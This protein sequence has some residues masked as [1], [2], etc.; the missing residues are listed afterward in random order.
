MRTTALHS[1]TRHPDHRTPG[2]GRRTRLRRIAAAIAVGTMAALVVPATAVQAEDTTVQIVPATS[3]SLPFDGT[4]ALGFGQSFLP[5]NDMAVRSASL[6]LQGLTGATVQL[7]ICTLPGSYPVSP[8]NCT[9]ADSTTVSGGVVN[10]TFAVPRLLQQNVSSAVL[11][12]AR[13]PDGNAYAYFSY[14]SLQLSETANYMN[15]SMLFGYENSSGSMNVLWGNDG[16]YGIYADLPLSL[17]Y[18]TPA[19]PAVT[20]TT[21]PSASYGQA[22]STTVLATGT[23]APG[24]AVSG[25]LPAGMSFNTATGVL[26]GTPTDVGTFTFTV[27]ASNGYGSPASQSL[28]LTVGASAPGAPASVTVTPGDH[29]VTATWPAPTSTGG[30]AVT[31][32]VEYQADGDPGWTTAGSTSSRTATIGS[33]TPGTQYAVRVRATNGAGA[34]PWTTSTPMVLPDTPSISGVTVV[35]T[36]GGATIRWTAA[37]GGTAIDSAT[38]RY[39]AVGAPTWT[40]DTFALTGTTGTRTITGL[41]NRAEHEFS[42]TTHN[43]IGDSAAA[44]GLFTPFRLAGTITSANT[45]LDTTPRVAGAPVDAQ[46]SGIPTGRSVELVY[47]AGTSDEVVL[48]DAVADLVGQVTL[49][50]TLPADAAVG[51]HTVTLR[52]VGST[53]QVTATVTIVLAPTATWTP[54]PATYQQPYTSSITLGGTSTVVAAVSGLPTGLSWSADGTVSGTPTSVGSYPLTVTVTGAGGSVT[55]TPTLAVQA[56]APGPVNAPVVSG[57]TSQPGELHVSWSAPTDAGAPGA[58]QYT[59]RYRAPGGSWTALAPTTATSATVTALPVGGTYDVEIT[60]TNASGISGS[61]ATATGPVWIASVVSTLTAHPADGSA[62]L[63]WATSTGGF[64]VTSHVITRTS[65]GPVTTENL[66]ST[67]SSAT[68]TGLTNGTTYTFTVAACTQL[69]VGD[70]CVVGTA[71]TVTVTPAAAPG[72]PA[73]GTATPGD[74]QV[75]VTWQTPA[76]D[77]GSAITGYRVDHK[78]TGSPSWTAGATLAATSTTTTVTGL[79]NA[80]TYEFRVVAINDA[81]SGPASATTTAIPFRFAPGFTTADGAPLNLGSLTAGTVI[82][83]TG[84]GATP[85]ATIVLELH[86]TPILLGTTVVA[87]DGTYRLTVTLPAGVTGSHTLVASLAGGAPVDTA[88]AV[89]APAPGAAAAV[90]AP[91]ASAPAGRALAATG[92]NARD[93][94]FLALLLAL[95]G[96]GAVVVSRTRRVRHP[97]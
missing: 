15:G 38:L 5:P 49:G 27:T 26:S 46:A 86:S 87:A 8:T 16:D 22:Y 3:P 40:T 48:D 32:D 2:G 34:S 57:D 94:A 88:V 45:S 19:A 63:S 24:L 69:A 20:T 50:G 68:V 31:Y 83:M 80:Q 64:P 47:A 58:L 71:D 70:P 35:E 30:A 51:M 39:R 56:A 44:D 97:R 29:S 74:G 53:A 85:G 23:P 13:T 62:T 59:V 55:I 37:D 96:T 81:G 90:T 79:T 60:A 61:A 4:G 77:G 43:A 73:V 6:T 67:A 93:V 76:D 84:S 1:T 18:S 10:G 72:A 78:A 25:T 7:S 11:V 95:A 42:L 66:P 75:T 91:A 17:T 14:L 92:A 9:A 82:T 12:R 28:A 54:A 52:V 33:L 21:L 65:G 89:G 41:T 36:D